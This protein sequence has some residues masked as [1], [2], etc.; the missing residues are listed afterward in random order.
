MNT[1]HAEAGS[2]G[3]RD[4]RHD[5][6]LVDRED[7]GFERAGSHADEQFGDGEAPGLGTH[8]DVPRGGERSSMEEFPIYGTTET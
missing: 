7:R 5:T 2:E 1:R 6:H 3:A 8:G 4:R